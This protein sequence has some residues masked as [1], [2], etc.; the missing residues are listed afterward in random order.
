MGKQNAEFLCMADITSPFFHSTSAFLSR[1]HGANPSMNELC[2]PVPS[3]LHVDIMLWSDIELV[4]L[5]ESKRADWPEQPRILALENETGELVC[6][7][8]TLSI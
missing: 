3:L 1:F 4:M 8:H 7:Y 2:L 6:S 5:E